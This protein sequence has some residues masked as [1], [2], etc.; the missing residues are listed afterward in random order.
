MSNSVYKNF[1]LV[2]RGAF[3]KSL[4]TQSRKSLNVSPS[5]EHKIKD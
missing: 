1:V 2:F 5:L 4:T 3:E